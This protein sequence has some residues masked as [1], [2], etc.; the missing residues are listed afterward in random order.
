MMEDKTDFAKFEN[1]V[2]ELIMFSLEPC[3]KNVN[4]LGPRMDEMASIYTKQQDTIDKNHR[5]LQDA[6]GIGK[7]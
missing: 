2:N 7:G 4:I 1:R 5:Q 6:L 3:I